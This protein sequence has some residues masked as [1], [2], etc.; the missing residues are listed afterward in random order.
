MLDPGMVLPK[1]IPADIVSF[2][3]P[4]QDLCLV[5]IFPVFVFNANRVENQRLVSTA[6]GFS[7]RGELRPGSSKSWPTPTLLG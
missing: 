5:I 1:R 3:G 4:T 2:L 7:G 6:R